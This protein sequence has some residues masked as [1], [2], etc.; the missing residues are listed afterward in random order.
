M[1]EV[2]NIVVGLFVIIGVYYTIA[3]FISYLS[4]IKKRGGDH[5]KKLKFAVLYFSFIGS[6]F[7][8][9][10]LQLLSFVVCFL[11]SLGFLFF[12]IIILLNK[13]N[14]REDFIN[15]L[16]MTIDE[17]E[18]NEK[19]DIKDFFIPDLTFTAKSILRY[20]PKKATRI[21]FI[22]PI[23]GTSLFLIYFYFVFLYDFTRLFF[24]FY[25]PLVLFWMVYGYK[26]NEKLY[27]EALNTAK[28]GRY[29][30]DYELFED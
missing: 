10:Y 29:K 21:I 13:K 26:K 5:L 25:I 16:A 27:R 9:A 11:Y 1:V 3:L 19:Y 7:I 6:F 20:G 30:G 18:G 8:I 14:N 24:I 28:E 4:K 15:N 2:E 22:L 23:I 17:V 12:L